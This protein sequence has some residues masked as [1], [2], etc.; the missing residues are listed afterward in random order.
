MAVRE[1]DLIVEPGVPFA[2]SPALNIPAKGERKWGEPDVREAYSTEITLRRGKKK[3][4]LRGRIRV[5]EDCNLIEII[6]IDQRYQ[7]MRTPAG[8][9]EIGL[10]IS[11]QEISAPT[12]PLTIY[13]EFDDLTRWQAAHIRLAFI[14]NGHTYWG[15][16]HPDDVA[17]EEGGQAA[18]MC[19]D[20]I[21]PETGQVTSPLF[22]PKAEIFE[23]MRF[24][25]TLR[26]P[27]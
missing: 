4:D 18:V 12:L 14:H 8:P 16:F 15:N 24:V 22:P 13:A 23:N 7:N 27:S 3:P 1:S 11:N 10:T 2:I 5:V 9:V 6:L 17:L 21:D 19:I 25:A 26:K 20:W